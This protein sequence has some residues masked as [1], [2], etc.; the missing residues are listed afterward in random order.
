MYLIIADEKFAGAAAGASMPMRIWPELGIF[1]D[2]Y[3]DIVDPNKGEKHHNSATFSHI[4]KNRCVIV[5]AR[6]LAIES[7]HAKSRSKD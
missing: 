4:E 2:D 5:S 1:A 6:I 3:E 7:T